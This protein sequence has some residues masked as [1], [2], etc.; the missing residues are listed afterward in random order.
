MS[1]ISIGQAVLSGPPI[2]PIKCL[3]TL[4]VLFILSRL[5]PLECLLCSKSIKRGRTLPSRR[6]DWEAPFSDSV[7]ANRSPAIWY[8]EERG[9]HGFCRQKLVSR[10]R[11]PIPRTQDCECYPHKL[12]APRFDSQARS[13][14]RA[15]LKASRK[16]RRCDF[17]HDMRCKLSGR[18]QR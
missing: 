13:S 14:S 11:H 18:C 3:P 6:I 1:P 5:C 8:P 9:F 4:S 17:I 15:C 16:W 7:H 10:D 12:I 2:S